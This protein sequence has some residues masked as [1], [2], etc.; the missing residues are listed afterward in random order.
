MSSL[1]EQAVLAPPMFPHA[2]S[3]PPAATASTV[4]PFGLA[5]AVPVVPGT[6]VLPTLH[7]C[8]ERQISV[9]TDGVPFIHEPSM[10]T[11]LTTTSQTKE[12][13]QLATDTESD[14]D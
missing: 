12:D 3:Q 7:L 13:N 14:T 8:P 4:R 6:E 10:K 9:T 11:Q 2:A 5:K 1:M